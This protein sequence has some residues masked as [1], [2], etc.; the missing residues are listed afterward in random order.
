MILYRGLCASA[1]NCSGTL[2]IHGHAGNCSCISG[3]PAI[4]GHKK[5]PHPFPGAGFLV[6]RLVSLDAP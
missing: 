6:S 3:I 5:T 2:V 4:H 1:G